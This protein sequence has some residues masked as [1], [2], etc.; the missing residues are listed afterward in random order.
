MD[1]VCK[2]FGLYV[3]LKCEKVDEPQTVQHVKNIGVMLQCEECDL[4]RLLYSKR[5]LSI[6]ETEIQSFLDD[7]AYTCGAT[8]I[9][10]RS[11]RA[12]ISEST[13][14]LTLLRNYIT[15]LAMHQF[16]SIVQRKM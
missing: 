8:L 16:A 9:F 11:S 7:I 10:L 15:Q 5:K 3:C 6:R 12:F 14:V 4:W 1:G 2:Q 13:V